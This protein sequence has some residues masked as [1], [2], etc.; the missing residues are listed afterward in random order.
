MVGGVPNIKAA[1]KWTRQSTK[2]TKRNLSAKTRLKTLFKKAKDGGDVS[3]A[4]SVESA[5]DK[6]ATKGI[7]HPNKA[8]RKKSRLAKALKAK[9]A[10]AP[11]PA[12][13]RAKK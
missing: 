5:F 6:A 2:R 12:K 8:A 3:V 13:S 11:T 10:A 7:I 1:I 4:P 9:P